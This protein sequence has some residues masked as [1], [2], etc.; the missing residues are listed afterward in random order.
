MNRSLLMSTLAAAVLA[1]PLLAQA[2]APLDPTTQA[3]LGGTAH[4][5]S[6]S[7]PTLSPADDATMS[8]G[9]PLVASM[10]QTY[11][12]NGATGFD[13]VLG[14]GS[15]AINNDPDAGT[16]TFQFNP[17]G[18]FTK[19]SVII[20]I[21]S[22]AGGLTDTSSLVDNGDTGRKGI[23]GYNAANKTRTQVNFADGFAA[24]YA[25][26]FENNNFTGVF[27]VPSPGNNYLNYITGQTP[28]NG[29]PYAV[30]VN[31]S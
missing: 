15:L 23:S 29:G 27:G 26:S 2:Q 9:G 5:S 24:D 21:D 30:T 10:P 16:I 28:N 8:N 12:G 4:S 22:V 19:N 25:I 3:L 14:K 6:A 11:T 31:Y 20:Y 13:G 17:S 7:A 1:A 18:D